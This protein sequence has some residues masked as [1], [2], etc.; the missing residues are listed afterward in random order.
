MHTRI[1]TSMKVI[2]QL[3]ISSQ[4]F[5]SFHLNAQSLTFEN[6]RLSSRF[7][8]KCPSNQSLVLRKFVIYCNSQKSNYIQL[9][10][11]IFTRTVLLKAIRSDQECTNLNG[12]KR[13]LNNIF[14][15]NGWISL[16]VWDL[17]LLRRIL[18]RT[19]SV[20]QIIY[21][22]SRDAA[23]SLNEVIFCKTKIFQNWPQ[24]WMCFDLNACVICFRR[25]FSPSSLNC[26]ETVLETFFFGNALNIKYL[27]NWCLTLKN[28][29]FVKWF[30]QICFFSCFSRKMVF[31]Q[32]SGKFWEKKTKRENL[33]PTLHRKKNDRF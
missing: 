13:N 22:E 11:N 27:W 33:F 6:H 29:K 10:A 12:F 3:T 31:L 30:P 4:I 24:L 26:Q 32:L 25:Q 7:P 16:D 14:A 20:S 15:L 23:S 5:N 2:N 21:F 9:Q 19:I 18:N 8:L 17:Q 28:W 1:S